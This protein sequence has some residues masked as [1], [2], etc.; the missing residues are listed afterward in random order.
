M[1]GTQ[2]ARVSESIHVEADQKTVWSVL[3][4][5]EDQPR[6]MVDAKSVVVLSPHREGTGVVLRCVTNIALGRTV[7]DDVTVTEYQ[8]PE[9]LGVRHLGPWY[10][11]I[12]AFELT[13]TTDGT[14]V[15]W[16]EEVQAPLGRV[17]E[18][19]ATALMPYVSRVFRR[20]LAQLKQVA[21]ARAVEAA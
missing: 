13:E 16:W 9:M 12:G 19:A 6:W 21:E 2:V 5:W 3:V 11:G 10:Q 14:L 1:E 18:A 15:Q 17:G 4:A 8:E 20:S 7:R